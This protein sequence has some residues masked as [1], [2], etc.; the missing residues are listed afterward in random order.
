M[1]NRRKDLSLRKDGWVAPKESDWKICL[2]ESL[3]P[4]NNTL[5]CRHSL[6]EADT[7][8]TTLLEIGEAFTLHRGKNPVKMADGRMIPALQQMLRGHGVVDSPNK[9]ESINSTKHVQ[10]NLPESPIDAGEA[11]CQPHNRRFFL[12]MLIMQIPCSDHQSKSHNS[13]GV[14]CMIFV[15]MSSQ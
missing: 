13:K 4:C 12:Q 11:T 15:N 14:R 2:C 6:E 8:R 10:E 9:A 5:F 1:T 3:Q 7:V